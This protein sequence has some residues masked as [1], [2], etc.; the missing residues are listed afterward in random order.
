M[1]WLL[2]GRVTDKLQQAFM[3]KALK[4]GTEGVSFLN[5]IKMTRE[6][7]QLAHVFCLSEVRAILASDGMTQ[8]A[9]GHF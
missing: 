1:N 2:S 6:K 7:Q 3:A 4:L 9:T 8:G 5:P